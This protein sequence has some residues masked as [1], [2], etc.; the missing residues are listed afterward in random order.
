MEVLGNVV[1]T[2][3][4]NDDSDLTFG[5]NVRS[6]SVS[7]FHNM[8]FLTRQLL[9]YLPSLATQLGESAFMSAMM[10]AFA[11]CIAF[12]VN[13]LLISSA[14]SQKPEIVIEDLNQPTVVIAE[15]KPHAS[16]PFASEDS[17]DIGV[18]GAPG[19]LS[20]RAKRRN[21]KS[22]QQE[23]A[24]FVQRVEMRFDELNGLL[25]EGIIDQEMLLQLRNQA[26]K[27]FNDIDKQASE[28]LLL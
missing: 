24:D 22:K 11:K 4:S 3:A 19:T 16:Q 18:V 10:S 5:S 27:E 8:F 28:L 14:V 7:C 2:K 13:W 17:K 20:K 6:L 15:P 9:L 23:E 12:F 25:C 1:E 21:K 26:V